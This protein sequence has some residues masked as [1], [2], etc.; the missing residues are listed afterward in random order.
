MTHTSM[1]ALDVPIVQVDDIEGAYAPAEII[2]VLPIVHAV[3][4]PATVGTP[5]FSCYKT[6][7]QSPSGGGMGVGVAAFSIDMVG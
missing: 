7:V 1:N 5:P 6:V 4:P 3:F 2:T